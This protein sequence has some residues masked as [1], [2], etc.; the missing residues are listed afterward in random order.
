MIIIWNAKRG[1]T[2]HSRVDA[3]MRILKEGQL[4]TLDPEKALIYKGVV[5]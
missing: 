3:A 2:A 1:I 5:I 4:V